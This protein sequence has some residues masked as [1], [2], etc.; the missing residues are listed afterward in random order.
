MANKMRL[1]QPGTLIEELK[2][3]KKDDPHRKKRGLIER[4]VRDIGY[5]ILIQ[6]VKHFPT[7]DAVEVVHGRWVPEYEY[8]GTDGGTAVSAYGCSVCH[9]YVGWLFGEV[10][11]YCPHCGAKMDGDGNA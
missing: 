11:K 8:G 2:E 9:G 3:M 7:V 4:W 10:Y 1:I 6:I 5:E